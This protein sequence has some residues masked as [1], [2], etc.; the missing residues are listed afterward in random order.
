MPDIRIPPMVQLNTINIYIVPLHIVFVNKKTTK[1]SVITGEKQKSH[2]ANA[3]WDKI[4]TVTN[5][6]VLSV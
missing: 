2:R 6:L 4:Y 5:E 3:L 1:Y